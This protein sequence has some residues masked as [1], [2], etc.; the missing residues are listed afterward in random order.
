VNVY[1]N[2]NLKTWQCPKCF[3]YYLTEG[4]A[5][6]CRQNVINRIIKKKMKPIIFRAIC[7]SIIMVIF[8]AMGMALAYLYNFNSE[9]VKINTIAVSYVVNSEKLT[10]VNLLIL[11]RE[12]GNIK[13]DAEFSALSTIPLTN[14]WN[15]LYFNLIKKNN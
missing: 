13:F 4:A 11:R 10:Q 5:H 14:N 6:D 9:L 2:K 12:Y 1:L 3:E 15:L 8:I 7:Y